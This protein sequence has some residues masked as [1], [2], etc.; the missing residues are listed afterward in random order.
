MN[1]YL[2]IMNVLN[3]VRNDAIT[4]TGDVGEHKI[5]YQLAISSNLTVELNVSVDS[6]MYYQAELTTEIKDFIRLLNDRTWHQQEAVIQNYINL[7]S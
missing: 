6:K 2:N 1:R 4:Y 3:V 7:L 5:K